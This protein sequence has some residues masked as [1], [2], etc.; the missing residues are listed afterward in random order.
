MR[1]FSECYFSWKND[2]SLEFVSSPPHSHTVHRSPQGI[3][4]P[5]AAQPAA[6]AACFSLSLSICLFGL[7]QPTLCYRYYLIREWIHYSNVC[8]SAVNQ[9]RLKWNHYM[10]CQ[11]LN[12]IKHNSQKLQLIAYLNIEDNSQMKI[13]RKHYC[14]R[15]VNHWTDITSR[16]CPSWT[17]WDVFFF[18]FI[19]TRVSSSWLIVGFLFH[20]TSVDF[21]WKLWR[22]CLSLFPM[23]GKWCASSSPTWAGG[24]RSI[25]L[26][27]SGLMLW[28]QCCTT[29]MASVSC[30]APVNQ[31]F[32][33]SL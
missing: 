23:A 30:S 28:L 3:T 31:S 22:K 17:A 24:R 13:I 29:T 12:Q 26:M 32:H 15:W 18:V 5:P 20:Q 11:L 27:A 7:N 6:P 2:F 33:H 1:L 4:P 25:T 14:G 8:F 16:M 9:L 21:M 10:K 19:C